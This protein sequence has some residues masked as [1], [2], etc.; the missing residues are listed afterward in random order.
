MIRRPPRATLFPYTTLFRSGHGTHVAGTVGGNAYGVAK[1]VRLVDVRIGACTNSLNT[2]TAIAG[3]DWVTGHHQPGQPAVANMSFGGGTNSTMDTAVR[4][5][6]N[7]GVVAV[8]AA[9]NG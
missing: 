4:N 8:I 6:I 7:D 2:S 3:I 1:G 5:M 9:G